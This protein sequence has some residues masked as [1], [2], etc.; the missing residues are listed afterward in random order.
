MVRKRLAQLKGKAEG[1][2]GE[3]EVVEEGRGEAGEKE[4]ERGGRWREQEFL[5]V[6]TL[7]LQDWKMITVEREG[8]VCV[9]GGGGGGGH[10]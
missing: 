4:R 9:E 8:G 6:V 2:G 7:H 10:S 5:L 3:K 1:R